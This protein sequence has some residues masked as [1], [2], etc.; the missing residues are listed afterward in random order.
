M[1]NTIPTKLILFKNDENTFKE[2]IKDFYEKIINTVSFD[3]FE[4]SSIEW[5]KITLVQNDLNVE[6]FLEFMQNHEESETW[7]SSLIGFFYQHGIGCN[8]NEDVA[9]KM[10]SLAIKQVEIV[11]NTIAK[12]LL[13]LFYYKDIILAKGNSGNSIGLTM[14]K[15]KVIISQFKNFKDIHERKNYSKLE[16]NLNFDNNNPETCN[17]E[18]EEENL[19]LDLN[20]QHEMEI[21]KKR[22]ERYIISARRGQRCAFNAGLI[23]YKNGERK[24]IPN[25]VKSTCWQEKE[26]IHKRL[27]FDVKKCLNA[28]LMNLSRKQ[29]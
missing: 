29:S 28:S 19:G 12:Y 21:E 22:F 5:I 4:N 16:E 8:V 14:I 17:N 6:T 2:L 20:R 13:S 1:D 24:G 26:I 7:F 27:K 18:E 11:N 9:L 3:N 25:D 23:N 10:Y 15:P